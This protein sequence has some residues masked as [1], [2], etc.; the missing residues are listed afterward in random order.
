M[1]PGGLF[2]IT[3]HPP[4]SPRPAEALPLAA[5]AGARGEAAGTIYLP[6]APGPARGAISHETTDGQNP[7]TRNYSKK[8]SR[9]IRLRSGESRFLERRQNF[10]RGGTRML[11]R[12]YRSANHQ[13]VRAGMD[14]LF[15]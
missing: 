10:S 14:G 5:G 15:G 4:T 7:I 9:L 3:T 8:S 2:V 11:C 6:G 13:P 1:K 12:A